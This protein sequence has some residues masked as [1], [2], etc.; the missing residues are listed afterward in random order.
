VAEPFAR[1]K[2]PFLQRLPAVDSGETGGF[3]RMDLEQK[4]KKGSRGRR[5]VSNYRN[6][7]EGEGHEQQGTE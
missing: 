1:V 2:R 6:T 5:S 3:G 7:T 4:Q